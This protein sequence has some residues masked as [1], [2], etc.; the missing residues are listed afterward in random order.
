MANV[1]AQSIE[2][3]QDRRGAILQ[4]PARCRQFDAPCTTMVA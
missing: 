3:L 4:A 2:L 1:V